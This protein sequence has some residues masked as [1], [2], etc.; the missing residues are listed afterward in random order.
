MEADIVGN[1][2]SAALGAGSGGV[3]AAAVLFTRLA[4]ASRRIGALES[5]HEANAARIASVETTQAAAGATMAAMTSSMARIEATL[6]RL[7]ERLS[8]FPNEVAAML[9]GLDSRPR[10]Q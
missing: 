7:S 3:T 4:E 10:R 9:G 2:F 5:K 8:A 1:I 6:D